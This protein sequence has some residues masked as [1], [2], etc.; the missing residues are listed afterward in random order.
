[1]AGRLQL[2][3]EWWY[4]VGME[5]SFWLDP[6]LRP[7]VDEWLEQL[8]RPLDEGGMALTELLLPLADDR[9]AANALV[10]RLVPDPDQQLVAE[11]IQIILLYQA[12]FDEM[13]MPLREW[14]AEQGRLVGH[15]AAE[16]RAIPLAMLARICEFL[17][18]GVSEAEVIESYAVWWRRARLQARYYRDLGAAPDL[19]P[20]LAGWDRPAEEGG[21]AMSQLLRQF[22]VAEGFRDLL[23]DQMGPQDPQLVAELVSWLARDRDDAVANG[24]VVVYRRPRLRPLP[25]EEPRLVAIPWENV[26]AMIREMLR[27]I[28]GDVGLPEEGVE[29]STQNQ[30]WFDWWRVHAREPKWYRGEAPVSAPPV[31]E[32]QRGG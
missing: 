1:V 28:T 18:S 23:L 13:G 9:L 3:L 8:R 25:G 31:F 2:W 30:F 22:Y 27:R 4:E 19:A 17:P 20:W 10:T 12:Q 15:T 24:F 26:Q 21:I 5:E 6:S 29:E 11:C 14:D 16:L 32:M 7:A